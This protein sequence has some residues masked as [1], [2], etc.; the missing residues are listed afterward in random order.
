MDCERASFIVAVLMMKCSF[1]FFVDLTDPWWTRAYDASL[2]AVNVTKDK[3][4][5][6]A[7]VKG[8]E[9]E[10]VQSQDSPYAKI[11]QRMVKANFTQFSKVTNCLNLSLELIYL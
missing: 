8:T 3:A 7:V 1:I 10:G 5:G 2:K 9:G 11:H 4:T 6:S